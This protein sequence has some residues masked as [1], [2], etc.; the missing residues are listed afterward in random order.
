M[1]TEPSFSNRVRN[2]IIGQPKP[3]GDSSIFHKLALVP[4]LAWVGLGA[5]GLS[6]SSYGPDEAYRTLGEHTYLAILLV[7]LMAFTIIVISACYSR[8]IE[9][10]PH[11]GGGYVVASKLLGRKSGVLSGSALLVDY[12]LTITTSI[13]GAGDAL[14]SFLPPTWIA[15]KLAL[16]A[17]FIVALIVLN[18]RGVKESVLFL[19][20]IFIIFLITHVIAILGGILG[21][22]PE[23]QATVTTVHTGFVTGGSTI[24]WAAL[25]MLLVHAYSLGGG[26]YT[27]IEAVSNGLPIMREPRVHT[28]KRTMI[29]M[30]ISLAFTASGLLLCYL[31]WKVQPV[32]GKTLNAVLFEKMTTNIPFGGVFVIVSL[33]AEGLL[34]IVAAQTGFIDGPR[35]LANMAV[36]S[37]LPRRFAALSDRLTTGNGILLMGGAALAALFYTDGDISHLLVMYSINVFLTFSLSIFGMLKHYIEERKTKVHWK[38]A[39]ALFTVGFVFCATILVITITEKFMHGGWVT[40]MITTLLV[41]LCFWVKS[42][43]VDVATKLRHLHVDMKSLYLPEPNLQPIDVKARTAVVLVGG[44]GSLG[45]Q[46]I[47]NILTT[48]PGVYKNLVF[49]SVAVIDS[50]VFKGQDAIDHLKIE[51]ETTLRKYQTTAQRLG[52]GAAARFAVGTEIAETGNDLC[53]KVRE[54]FPNSTFFTGKL[55]FEKESWSHRILHNET[56]YGLQ[57]RL[58]WSG[59][60]MVILP[61]KLT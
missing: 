43:Y 42:H 14:F 48:F 19:A 55:I 6:S 58:Q 34:L 1:S 27:G 28:A 60:T 22:I 53:I 3:L 13:A 8:I 45:L 21:H 51:T 57:K 10:F 16:E 52:L 24:G 54:E 18:L 61:I 36:D 44:Y 5:D 50:G 59:L 9:D 46:T 25:L 32:D 15:H 40:L 31:L 7:I 29:Y 33:L 38:K 17:F 23:M 39:V 20:P 11:G 26:T 30:A 2:V 35:V 37:W 56:A 4:F 47:K 41:S 49:V 12:I